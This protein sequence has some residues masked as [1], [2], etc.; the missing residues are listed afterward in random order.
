MLKMY[1]LSTGTFFYILWQARLLEQFFGLR[2]QTHYFLVKL[3]KFAVHA[4]AYSTAMM[5][6]NITKT[7]LT[8]V[9][10]S[11]G[12]HVIIIIEERKYK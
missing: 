9:F 12:I 2:D 7:F 8:L 11:G 6:M 5:L 10:T 1:R 3:V 4:C